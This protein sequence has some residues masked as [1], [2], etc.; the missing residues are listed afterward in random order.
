M[1]AREVSNQGEK[2]LIVYM[3]EDERNRFKTMLPYWNK[4]YHSV[5]SFVSGQNDIK[6][7]L[8]R[9]VANHS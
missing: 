8:K 1:R 9:I 5:V 3:R 6:E 7:A 2:C 4:E